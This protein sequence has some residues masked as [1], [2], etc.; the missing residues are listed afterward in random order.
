MG[1]LATLKEVPNHAQTHSI[2]MIRNELGKARV[3]PSKVAKH[4]R[5][6]WRWQNSYSHNE[7]TAKIAKMVDGDHSTPLARSDL[8]VLQGLLPYYQAHSFDKEGLLVPENVA[9]KY[10]EIVDDGRGIPMPNV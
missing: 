10:T 3:N 4:M 7:L 1:A 8:E 2:E 5:N 6:E 9:P